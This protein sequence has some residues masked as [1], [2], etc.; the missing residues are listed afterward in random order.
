[1]SARFS[2]PP[3]RALL[4]LSAIYLCAPPPLSALYP[5]SLPQERPSKPDEA[6]LAK[7]LEAA[8]AYCEKLKSMALHFVCREN[9]AEKTHE[10]GKTLLFRRASDPRGRL[11]PIEDLKAVKTVK[12][13]YVYDYQMIKMGDSLSEKRDFLEENGKK[14]D[15]KDVALQTLRMTGK[16]LVYGPVGFL[17]RAWQPHF[18]YEIVGAENLGGRKAAILRAVP[19]ELTEENHSFGRIWVDEEEASVLRIEWEPQSIDNLR[20]VVQSP[21][22][23]LKRRVIWTA[24]YDVVKNGIRFPGVQSI[25]EYLTTPSAKEHLKYEAEYVYDR[26]KFFTVETEVVFK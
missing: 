12:T 13:S 20:D 11:V 23:E 18:R 9:I 25:K 6:K 14:R 7:I 15:K 24:S 26:Y 5:Q 17:S 2:L 8:G 16:Y 3:V 21:I 19:R 10:F 1:V 4:A 22:G